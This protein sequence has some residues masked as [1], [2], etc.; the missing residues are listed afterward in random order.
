[1]KKYGIV[2]VKNS[3]FF[4]SLIVFA[5]IFLSGCWKSAQ[6]ESKL[7]VI[8][9]LDAAN[10][11][12]CHIT[13]SINI[14]FEN[15]EDRMKSLNKKDRYVLYCSNYACTAAPFAA[16]MMKEA[17]FEHVRYYHGGIAQWYQKGLPY[18]GKAQM[19][20]LKEENEPMEDDDHKGVKSVT[21]DELKSEM[22]AAKLL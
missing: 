19:E 22:I 18:T 17:G 2:N 5:T 11:E 4:F 10:Y 1:M 20:Y 15:L 13:G 3:K 14:P 7:V 16:N 8:N 9:V 21:F 6:E 12:D